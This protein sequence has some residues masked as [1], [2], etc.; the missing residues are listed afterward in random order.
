MS[1]GAGNNM[2][3]RDGGQSVLS[4]AALDPPLARKTV[5]ILSHV[6]H[7]DGTLTKNFAPPVWDGESGF[8]DGQAWYPIFVNAY[9]KE[10]GELDL[11]KE[12]FP[13]VQGGDRT[14]LAKLAAGKD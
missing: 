14:L 12:K 1:W 8:L 6:Q 3:F 2:G 7:R 11:L 5:R 13:F 4:A 9:L 10:T